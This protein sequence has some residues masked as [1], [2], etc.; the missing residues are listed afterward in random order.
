MNID[1]LILK[2]LNRKNSLDELEALESWKN[3]SEKNIAFLNMMSLGMDN[4]SYK[5]YDTNGAWKN[6]E[7]QIGPSKNT[8]AVK[9]LLAI[10]LAILLAFAVYSF[11][12]TRTLLKTYDAPNATAY[13]QLEDASEIWLNQN[14]SV[15][16]LALF[17]DERRVALEGEAFFD[18]SHNPDKPFVIETDGGTFVKVLGTSFNLVSS[19]EDFDLAV[20]SGVVELHALNRIIRVEKGERIKRLD[21]A[22]VKTSNIDVNLD[23][24][25]SGVL[26]FEDTPIARVF[27]TLEK[28]F[29]VDFKLDQDVKVN[30]CFLRNRYDNQSLE[31][32][33][34]ELTKLFSMQY[35]Y[36]DNVVLIQDINCY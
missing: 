34:E 17:D 6:L 16:Q 9:W 32:I 7:G 35:I 28:Q 23:S 11:M 29:Q 13:Y 1:K 31:E 14:A 33:L 25:K 30:Q 18:I 2:L 19:Q 20:Y 21:G 4:E 22:Y 8:I 26:V 5:S 3:D 10:S 12:N 24:W 27:E 15:Q 36:Q